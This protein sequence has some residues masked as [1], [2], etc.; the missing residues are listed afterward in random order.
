MDNKLVYSVFAGF[1]LHVCP[2]NDE[3]KCSSIIDLLLRIDDPQFAMD[4]HFIHEID[5]DVPLV[6]SLRFHWP[7]WTS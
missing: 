3:V 1:N 6:P 4:A 5:E 2:L 7:P